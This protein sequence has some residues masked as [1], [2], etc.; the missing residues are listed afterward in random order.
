MSN[1]SPLPPRAS[2]SKKQA[3]KRKRPG[4]VARFFRWSLATIC[5]TALI[6]ILY[7]AYQ[8]IHEADRALDKVALPELPGNED[9]VVVA[10]EDRAQ[11][12]PMAI[13]LLGLD[14]RKATGSMNTDVIILAAL[15]PHSD[16]ATLVTVPRDSLLK[17]PGYADTKVNEKYAR[18]LRSARRDKGLEDEAARLD[19]MEQMRTFMSSYFGIDI[20]HTAI[21]DFQGFIDVIDALGG[22]RVYVDQDMRYVDR[23]DNTNIDLRKGEQVLNGKQALDFVRY[24]KSNA[25]TPESN[26]FERNARQARVLRAVVD[27]LKSFGTLTKLDD[28]IRAVGD[29]LYTD[30]P[31]EQIQNLVKAYYDIDGSRIRHIPLE[32]V[33]RSP[34]VYID[35]DSLAK[36]KEA[37]AEEM[38]PEGR[39]VGEPDASGASVT[40]ESAS[41]G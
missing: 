30:I 36:A 4:K 13:L 31:R 1:E 26:D 28:L 2:R 27:K 15:N 18:F 3:I 14:H 7:I 10:K 39:P 24:R 34:Y 32:G 8:V 40:G 12:K 9:K 37:L 19:A 23:A 16:T 38:R 21:I 20:R 11:V 35:E 22:V 41:G 29:N 33:W 5:V 25:G 17:V 6:C